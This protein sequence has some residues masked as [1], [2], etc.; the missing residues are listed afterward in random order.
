MNAR[1][2]AVRAGLHRA[3][4]EL[5]Q[6]LTSVQELWNLLFFPVIGMFAM[7]MFRGNDV[8]GTGFSLG[9]HAVPG[10]LA[11]NMMSSGMMGLAITL[12]MDREDG[13]LL[14]AK[15]TP[16]GVIGYLTGR[17]LSRG[18]LT[19]VGLLLPL[20]PAAFVFGGLDL[21]RASAWLTL[22]WVL[23]LGLPA[24]LAIGAILGSL[25]TNAQSVGVLMVPLMLLIAIS[26]VFYPVTAFPGWV[27]W[28]AQA[29]P[30][31]WLGLGMRSAM[32]PDPLAA[33]EIGDS[34]RHLETAGM[35]GLW[36]VAGLVLAPRVLRRMARRESGTDLAAR[37]KKA[38]QWS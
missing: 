7:F 5:S 23:A 8:P 25:F 31:Y 18:G 19:V 33:A 11:M 24:V 29:F 27:E 35:L 1:M 37:R 22:A 30:L 14:R 3:R 6:A 10:I 26:G 4:L 13:T 9:A 21:G 28:I 16:N 12:T 34:W 36:A 38:M 2:V 20:V 15:A 17:I 32:L